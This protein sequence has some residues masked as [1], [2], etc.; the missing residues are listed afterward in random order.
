MGQ[1]QRVKTGRLYMACSKAMVF[2]GHNVWT[3]C[4][5]SDN[6]VCMGSL[7]LELRFV[8]HLSVDFAVSYSISFFLSYNNII[9]LNPGLPS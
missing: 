4:S 1:S 7:V 2:C 5:L 6:Y 3:S 8:L 9:Y